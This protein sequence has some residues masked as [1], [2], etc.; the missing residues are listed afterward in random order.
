MWLCGICKENEN[1]EGNSR[2][3][4]LNCSVKF[5]LQSIKERI[6]SDTLYIEFYNLRLYTLD[7]LLN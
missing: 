4:M 2:E 3:K 6:H 1:G 7:S 5:V